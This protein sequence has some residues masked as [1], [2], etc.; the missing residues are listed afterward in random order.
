VKHQSIAR[1]TSSCLSLGEAQDQ[2]VVTVRKCPRLAALAAVFLG[3]FL[4]VGVAQFEIPTSPTSPGGATSGDSID[5]GGVPVGETRSSQYTFK[6]LES[7]QTAARV[8]IYDPCPPFGLSGLASQS[9]TLQ[10]GQAVTFNVTFAPTEVKPYGCSFKIRAEGG[11]PV[12]VKET[13]VQL[14]G[15]GISQGVGSSGTSESPSAGLP[16]GLIT[17]QPPVT[18]GGEVF[19]GTTDSHGKFQ[20]SVPP[21]TTVAGKLS[22][23]E[24]GPIAS[25]VVRLAPTS[26]G[27]GVFVRGYAEV[28]AKAVSRISFFGSESVDLGE[29][30]L[31]P[32]VEATREAGA[33]GEPECKVCIELAPS[34]LRFE[35][36][37]CDED[38]GHPTRELVIS[39]C[40]EPSESCP[41][42]T[43]TLTV[44]ESKLEKCNR[45]K[46]LPAFMWHEGGY[47]HVFPATVVLPP[48][49]TRKIFIGLQKECLQVQPVAPASTPGKAN[50]A[51]VAGEATSVSSDAGL[52]TEIPLGVSVQCG[53]AWAASPAPVIS[54]SAPKLL[55]R[56][57][58]RRFSL[59]IAESELRKTYEYPPDP[60]LYET[61]PLYPSSFLV[62][63]TPCRLAFSTNRPVEMGGRNLLNEVDCAT[64]RIELAIDVEFMNFMSP[65]YFP[66]RSYEIEQWFELREET[67]VG[68]YRICESAD[69]RYDGLGFP[70]GWDKS[71]EMA[72]ESPT[73]GE[74]G[75]YR[76]S[77]LGVV[78]EFDGGSATD[79]FSITPSCIA[80][81]C[82][83]RQAVQFTVMIRYSFRR[84]E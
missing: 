3:V 49:Q 40:S 67:P 66:F 50:A 52:Y 80:T 27:Y 19:E 35:M 70:F 10:P 36:C 74:R 59:E 37:A 6:V 22:E 24:G 83:D 65:G 14:S 15:R 81:C 39:N 4:A 25:E 47:W 5:F 73:G 75:V 11:R 72:W 48:G 7:S 41:S 34:E 61:Y 9:M 8:T 58:G 54:P 33:P 56:V 2:V 45:Y 18:E 71:W 78:R 51:V 32:E 84:V 16:L 64:G 69:V 12:Q 28:V 79:S 60:D 23:C 57:E 62:N 46:A 63:D 43:V 30:C 29:V 17:T 44:D 1:R 31:T 53:Q 20:I 42:C 76:R 26:D 21:T 13:V 77:S 82:P 38:T 68:G 55:V